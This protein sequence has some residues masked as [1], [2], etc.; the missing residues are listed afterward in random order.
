MLDSFVL[1]CDIH[2]GL[3]R[4]HGL[5]NISEHQ[6][7]PQALIL[8]LELRCIALHGLSNTGVFGST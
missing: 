4:F 1:Q 5:E 2:L 3:D 7:V 6:L 8:A